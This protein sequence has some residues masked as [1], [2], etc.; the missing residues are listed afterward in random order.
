MIESIQGTLASRLP[1]RAVVELHGVGVELAIPMGTFKALGEPG[2]AVRLLCHLHWREE[3]PQLFG[4][5]TEEERS[6]FRMLNKVNK[7]GPKLALT[8]LSAV[9]PDQLVGMI[10]TEDV[11]GLTAVKGIGA[12]LASRLVL[13]LKDSV[14]QLGIAGA[15]AGSRPAAGP[16]TSFPHERDVREALESLGY[17]PREIEKAL[18]ETAPRL[19]AGA[20]LEEV[21][22]AVLQGFSR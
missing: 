11:R 5:L 18:V 9:S 14:A 19:P 20:R 2:S 12:K 1:H 4:F 3:G 17:S 8:I 13:E 6:V 7:I 15:E 10:L 16:R 22:E 21:I